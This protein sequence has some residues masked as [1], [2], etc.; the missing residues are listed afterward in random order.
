MPETDISYW[1]LSEHRIAPPGPWLS[2]PAGP[3]ARPLSCGYLPPPSTNRVTVEGRTLPDT[4]LCRLINHRPP[5]C[6]LC[7]PNGVSADAHPIGRRAR[8]HLL[9][10]VCSFPARLGVA[11]RLVSSLEITTQQEPPLPK[12]MIR[13]ARNQSLPRRSTLAVMVFC[14]TT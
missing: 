1:H 2:H 8:A 13:S 6:R 3:F 9:E 10:T 14:L 7:I 11:A 12:T 4:S 5:S